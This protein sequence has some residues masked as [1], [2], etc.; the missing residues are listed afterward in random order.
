MKQKIDP[1]LYE[2][3]FTLSSKENVDCLIYSRNFKEL[4]VRN[5]V[6]KLWQGV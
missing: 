4:Y 5:Q 1:S 6:S 2:S 3:V